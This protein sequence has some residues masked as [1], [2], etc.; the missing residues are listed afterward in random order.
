[1]QWSQRYFREGGTS[2]AMRTMLIQSQYLSGDFAGA[3]K[4]LMRRDPG[5]RARW[6]RSLPK[7]G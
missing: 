6:Q 7:T 3:A 4:E 1:M 5:R 2:G